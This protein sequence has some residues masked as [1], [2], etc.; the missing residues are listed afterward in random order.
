MSPRAAAR[1]VQI[2]SL[3]NGI[4]NV[5]VRRDAGV[6]TAV[7]TGPGTMLGK[8]SYSVRPMM[9]ISVRRHI[10]RLAL[11]NWREF[12]F[13]HWPIDTTV[14]Q[15]FE[16][17]L[18]SAMQARNIKRIPFIW[19]RPEGASSCVMVFRIG[20][21]HEEMPKFSLWWSVLPTAAANGTRPK[22]P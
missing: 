6:T 22:S 12:P 16:K 2:G 9:G 21:E 8:P 17:L 11:R 15:V 19:F 3:L 14:E 10:Q 4:P 1:A 5:S 13:P 20:L 7:S 18:V